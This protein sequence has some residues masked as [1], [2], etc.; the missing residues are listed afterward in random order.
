[1]NAG[2]FTAGIR[3]VHDKSD[4]VSLVAKRKSII[5]QKTIS[6]SSRPPSVLADVESAPGLHPGR[7]GSHAGTGTETGIQLGGSGDWAALP[8]R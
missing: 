8:G 3:F 6:S 5:T 7:S 4:E 1:M 2:Q